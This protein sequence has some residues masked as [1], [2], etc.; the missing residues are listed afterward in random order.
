MVSLDD[1]IG[2]RAYLAY[3]WKR[4]GCTDS[5]RRHMIARQSNRSQADKGRPPGVC[6]GPV[7]T[8]NHGHGPG[9]EVCA[10]EYL[11][12]GANSGDA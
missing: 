7:G 6:A 1:P 10:L 4:T 11:R 2:P 3:I 12:L 9:R 8:S 5:C